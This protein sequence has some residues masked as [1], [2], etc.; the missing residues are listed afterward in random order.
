M[1]K[2]MK[3]IPYANVIRHPACR[4]NTTPCMSYHFVKY[5]TNGL[6]SDTKL[7]YDTTQMAGHYDIKG[8]VMQQITV[9][10]DSQRRI[11]KNELDR[12]EEIEAKERE[13][14]RKNDNFTQTTPAGWKRMR[15][16]IKSKETAP[17]LPLYMF[18]AEHIDPSCGAVVADQ[19]FLAERMGVSI[20]TI[21]RWL[22]LL[23]EHR[24]LVRIPVAGRVCAYALN[25]DEVWK[26]YK[27]NKEYAAFVTKTLV[28]KDGEIQR[29]IMSMFS[30]EK[31]A[32][33]AQQEQAE[34]DNE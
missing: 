26:G 2:L 23:E 27:N 9:A 22:N 15:E 14:A 18:F 34:L 12:L 28:N 11:R 4:I 17:A 31:Q 19:G 13:K 6:F 33:L 10:S 32:E 1:P 24:A 7:S 29:R 20:R 3:S 16:M 8:E 25:P 30:P 21:Q 5:D